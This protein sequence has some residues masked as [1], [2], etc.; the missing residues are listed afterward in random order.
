MQYF[1]GDFS[2]VDLEF[3]VECGSLGIGDSIFQPLFAAGH[4]P[5]PPHFP[6]L[7]P[8]TEKAHKVIVQHSLHHGARSLERLKGTRRFY[9]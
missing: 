8:S 3:R 7:I 6:S 1:A 4:W 5:T 2:N 9:S